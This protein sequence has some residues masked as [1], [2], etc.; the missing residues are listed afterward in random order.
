MQGQKEVYRFFRVRKKRKSS[1][2]KDS[3]ENKELGKALNDFCRQSMIQKLL[4]DILVDMTVCK[5]EGYDIK[6][7]VTM[8]KKE[9][10]RIYK[11]I[12]SQKKTKKDKKQLDL[13]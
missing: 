5:L 3:I 6:G 11:K 9:I 2:E 13:F 1:M 10:D 8:L 4:A 7:Y 12:T